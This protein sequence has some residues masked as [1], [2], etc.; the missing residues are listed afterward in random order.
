MAVKHRDMARFYRTVAVSAVGEFW[1]ATDKVLSVVAVL[2]F[3]LLL[4]NRS[5]GE[6]VVTAWDGL[7][8]WW[9]LIPI[10]MLVIYRLLRANYQK[11]AAL[12][13]KLANFERLLTPLQFEGLELATDIRGFIDECGPLGPLPAEEQ[14]FR[15]YVQEHLSNLVDS[16][17]RE[18]DVSMQMKVM[19]GF[20]VNG[21]EKRVEDFINKAGMQIPAGSHV[22]R[23]GIS[24]RRGL[25]LLARDM[26][27]IALALNYLAKLP[28]WG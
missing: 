11:F 2:S 8:P 15:T 19:N 12:E 14:K 3:L 28:I 17:A 24:D 20:K 5:L 9:S 26:E 6:K 10:G 23:E 25:A 27:E 18:R 13:E 1:T 7:S 21:L 4:L 22:F 16:Y